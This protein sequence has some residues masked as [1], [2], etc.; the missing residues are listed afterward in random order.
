MTV[1]DHPSDR[2]W[3]Q[4]RYL[5]ARATPP[6]ERGRTC[7]PSP[8]LLNYIGEPLTRSGS[9]A[10]DSRPS[11]SGDRGAGRARARQ[12]TRRTAMKSQETVASRQRRDSGARSAPPDRP[13]ASGRGRAH[14]RRAHRSRENFPYML[15]VDGQISPSGHYAC[16]T[17][18]EENFSVRRKNETIASTSARGTDFERCRLISARGPST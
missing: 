9:R 6:A 8:L 3:P 11:A 16:A 1:A 15:K 5:A 7:A 18:T 14:R 4:K 2:F 12:D 17:A 13:R 10:H